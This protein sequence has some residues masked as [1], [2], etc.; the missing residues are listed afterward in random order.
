MPSSAWVAVRAQLLGGFG[1]PRANLSA[2]QQATGMRANPAHIEFHRALVLLRM[3]ISCL[4]ALAHAE[5]AHADR[6]MNT[7][8]YE[9]LL[10][11]L[12]F[13]LPQALERAGCREPG[14]SDHAR[15]GEAKV[16]ASPVLRDRAV[17]LQNLAS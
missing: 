9:L 5:A 17:G 13:L 6:T 11:Y 14:L 3:A 7:M 16:A 12:H 8:V 15:D 4:V 1:D 10:P 2:W